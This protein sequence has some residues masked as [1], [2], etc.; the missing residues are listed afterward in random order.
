VSGRAVR[1]GG[2]TGETPVVTRVLR[3]C[4]DNVMPEGYAHRVMTRCDAM[5]SETDPATTP[6]VVAATR[7]SVKAVWNTAPRKRV[8]ADRGKASVRS[9]AGAQPVRSIRAAGS[10]GGGFKV[11]RT[12]AIG[13]LFVFRSS[14]FVQAT[15]LFSVGVL[16]IG[17]GVMWTH[18]VDGASADVFAPQASV[19]ETTASGI[20]DRVQTVTEPAIV[21]GEA[22]QPDAPAPLPLPDPVPAT[23]AYEPTD[24][25]LTA[26][27]KGTIFLSGND[28][29]CGHVNPTSARTVH[30]DPARGSLAWTI[31]RGDDPTPLYGGVGAEVTSELESLR[32]TYGDGNYLLTFIYTTEDGLHV[33]KSR[34]IFIDTGVI[35]PNQYE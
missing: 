14:S 12:A 28:C 20:E 25:Y 23:E 34:P 21:D 18:E 26:L 3:D 8:S 11:I 6:A 35:T 9:A 31:A 15:A 24:A 5:M 29:A 27:E 4:V 17:S 1:T 33:A 22:I 13:L 30:M 16:A 19:E 7:A 10:F 32:T 2:E